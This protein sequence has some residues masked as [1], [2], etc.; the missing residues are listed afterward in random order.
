MNDKYEMS[1]IFYYDDFNKYID[2]SIYEDIKFPYQIFIG[3]RG[4][5]K[6][7]SALRFAV[8]RYKQYKEKFMWMRRTA[9]ELEL[10]CDSPRYGEGGN[11][12]KEINEKYLESYGLCMM[13][14]KVA[15]I[16]ERE[17]DEKNKRFLYNSDKM[18]GYG[19]ALSNIASARGMNF[20]DAD[21]LFY[22]EFI[23]ER[24]VKRIRAE[25]EA[26]LNAIETIA[27]N[28][29]L[30]GKPP[31]FVYFL[32]NAFNIYN[33]LFQELGVID[34]VEKAMRNR[35]EHIYLEE[36]GLAIHLLE[37]TVEFTESKKQTSLYKLTSNSNYADMA[38]N[39]SFVYN[40]FSLV[41]Y[42]KIQ[43]MRPVC[44]CA[45]FNIYSKKGTREY[46]VT[47]APCRASYYDTDT[48]QGQRLWR[49][50]IGRRLL[51]EFN[52]GNIFFET[53]ALKEQFLDLIGIK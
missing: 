49:T 39:N 34:I 30:Q 7:Y 25:G 50:E 16:Y 5:G 17:Y 32:A 40:D 48:I 52:D 27:R 35:Q 28:R 47:Y 29:E 20:T 46:Y 1:Q 8:Y 38:L 21:R 41:Q 11:P 12:F 36:R 15:G 4:T 9:D 44:R 45:G 18:M 53:Y 37:N 31:L 51:P 33:P 14:K 2:I 6:T 26:I 3:G 19:C 10:L 13:S 42:R 24:H 43:G 23:Y 22:D